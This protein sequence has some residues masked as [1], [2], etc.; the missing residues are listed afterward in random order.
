MQYAGQLKS[1]DVKNLS[2]NSFNFTR[3]RSKQLWDDY[4]KQEHM[5]VSLGQSGFTEKEHF[6]D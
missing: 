5:K 4:R 6:F 3:D 2:G 1:R